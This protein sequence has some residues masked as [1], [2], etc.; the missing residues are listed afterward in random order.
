MK[1]NIKTIAS[2]F[3]LVFMMFSSMVISV[4]ASSTTSSKTTKTV[5]NHTYTYYSSISSSSNN[6]LIAMTS[7]EAK[8]STPSGY[9]GA[10]AYLYSETGALKSN[11]SW[12]YND[13]SLSASGGWTNVCSYTNT[14]SYYS[15]GSVKLYNGDG[16]NTYSCTKSPCVTSRSAANIQVSTNRKG[17]IYGSK[18]F[19][20][21]IGVEPDLILAEG[22]QGIIGYV[23]ASDLEDPSVN[24]PEEAIQ[25]ME[26][27]VQTRTIPVYDE[28]NEIVID[29]YTIDNRGIVSAN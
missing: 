16:Y 25:Y 24:S 12:S 21:E 1:K 22:N 6:L 14:G 8:N 5:Y 19:L 28:S 26:S 17:E 29:T 11:S 9:I 23:R 2:T 20:N 27:L 3:M 18:Y 13:K 10:K 7:V 4:S 15:Q